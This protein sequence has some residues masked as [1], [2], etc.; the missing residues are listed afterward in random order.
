[1]F[2]RSRASN[3]EVKNRIWCKFKLVQDLMSVLVTCQFDEDPIKTEGAIVST[4]LF[5]STQGQLTPKVKEQDVAGIRT[6]LRIYAC[7][8]YLKFYDDLIKTE[9]VIM[10]T[11]SP[12]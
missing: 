3:S 1:M 7:P 6:R 9:I 5:S 12:L 2:Q 4:P 11:S 10:L 8:S